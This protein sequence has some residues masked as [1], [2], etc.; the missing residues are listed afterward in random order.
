LKNERIHCQRYPY[1]PTRKQRS[2]STSNSSTIA[3]RATRTQAT[4][5]Q[6]HSLKNAAKKRW[7]LET[8]MSTIE[9]TTSVSVITE[10]TRI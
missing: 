7:Q 6:H 2:R 3:S 10:T 9:S 4:Y 5:R 8:E 1:R